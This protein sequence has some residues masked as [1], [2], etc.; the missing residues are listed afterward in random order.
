MIQTSVP[1]IEAVS[2]ETDLHQ[3]VHQ[4]NRCQKKLLRVRTDKKKFIWASIRPVVTLHGVCH[5]K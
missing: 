3:R 2:N 5:A 4:S 1:V